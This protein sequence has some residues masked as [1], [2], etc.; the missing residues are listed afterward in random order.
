MKLAFCLYKY[1]PYGGLQRDLLRIAEACHRRGGAIRVYTF[2]WQG[3]CPD[4]LELCRVPKKGWSSPA[5]N[6]HFTDWVLEHRRQQPVDCLIGFNKM[7]GLDVYYAA[8]GCYEARVSELYG[9]FYRMT[10]RYRHFSRYEAAV[11]G[12]HSSTQILMISRLQMPVFQRYYRTPN[13]RLHLLPPGIAPRCDSVRS[14][15]SSCAGSWA[16]PTMSGYC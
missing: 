15:A 14:C 5:R 1:F 8:D 10:A 4:W 3:D 11:F 13:Q 6:R 12:A 16:W 9:R 7:P 2:E